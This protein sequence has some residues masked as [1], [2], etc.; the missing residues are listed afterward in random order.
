MDTILTIKI[1]NPNPNIKNKVNHD[2]HKYTSFFDKIKPYMVYY[3][4]I[5]EFNLEEVYSGWLEKFQNSEQFK[6]YTGNIRFYH[7]STRWG[8]TLLASKI[9]YN[10]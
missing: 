8:K 6:T 5:K 4:T 3:F 7:I 9:E 10:G 2:L 1:T